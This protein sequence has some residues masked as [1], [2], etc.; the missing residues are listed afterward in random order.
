M[1][2]FR[3]DTVTKPCNKMRDIM[4]HAP[5]GDD[6]Y[7]DDESINQLEA[8]AMSKMH[9]FV[10]Q[11]QANLLALMA[12]CERGDEYICGQT[13]HNYKFEGGGAAVIGSIQSQPIENEADDSHFAKTRLLTLENTIGGKVLGIDY[14][15]KAREFVD[16]H[17]LA[18]HLDGARAFNVA[19][20]LNLDIKEITKHFDSVSIC[21]SKGLG[22]PVGSL[23]LGSE[24]LIA[25][26]RRWRKVLGGGM[27]QA[28]MLAAAGQYALENNTQRL[29]D[30]HANARYLAQQLSE[31]SDFEVNM[32]N[33]TN[34]VYATFDNSI[35]ITKL[36]A[37]LKAHDIV[38]SPSKQ[39]RLVT[40][41]GITKA[42]I[43]TFIKVLTA[44][45]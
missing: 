8:Y 36:A 27:R 37:D 20:E 21:L 19:A 6:V 11:A 26:A 10:A 16:Q 12:H 1:I 3:S 18:L 35:N 41:L 44:H 22:A 43:D 14:L 31:I 15:I 39:L 28:G 45:I 9:F 40:H 17:N 7:G 24:Q 4:Y 13:A 25:K 29:V 30:D 32:S 33:T 23:L 5:V 38:F 2:D 34:M 42:D